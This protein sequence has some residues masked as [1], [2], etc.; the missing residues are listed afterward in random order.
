[1]KVER[2]RIVTPRAQKEK[3]RGKKKISILV[4]RGISLVRSWTR[5]SISTQVRRG[6]TREPIYSDI[7]REKRE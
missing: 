5:L 3:R 1:M 7:C 6:V 4:S 2:Y